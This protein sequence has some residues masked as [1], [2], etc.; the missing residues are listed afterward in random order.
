M[1]TLCNVVQEP[2]ENI[3]HVK[4]LFNNVV[5]LLGQHCIDKN[6]V[7]CCPRDSRQHCTG[8][9]SNVV[10]I[11]SLFG[12]FYFEPVDFFL[13]TSCCKCRTNIAQ[14]FGILYKKIPGPTLNKKTKLYGTNKI[15][16]SE[17]THYGK[18]SIATFSVKLPPRL[19][20]LKTL[21]SY[22]LRDSKPS[23]VLSLFLNFLPRQRLL[24]L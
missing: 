21:C 2:P 23:F 16:S 9:K 17:I 19:T 5:I 12:D 6:S 10:W 11:T 3:A 15:F 4:I 7:Q 13:I 1:K 20:V 24:L 18:S 8:K 22:V 14:I